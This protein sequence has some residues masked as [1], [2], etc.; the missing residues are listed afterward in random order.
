M[1]SDRLRSPSGT[2]GRRWATVAVVPA[3][4]LAAALPAAAAG[5]AAAVPSHVTP[6]SVGYVGHAFGTSVTVASGLLGSGP[7]ANVVTG[8][9]DT[10][11]A[12]RTNTTAGVTVPGVLSTGV[13][14]TS[15]TSNAS[16]A[17]KSEV[18]T[19]QVAGVSLLGGEIAATAVSDSSTSSVAG[20]T[21]STSGQSTFVGLTVDGTSEAGSP[22]ANTVIPLPGIGSVTLNEQNATPGSDSTQL[23][24]TSIDIRVLTAN[25]FGLPVGAR[26]IVG[27]ALSGLVTAPSPLV[28]GSAFGT[29]LTALDGA[30]V[31]GRTAFQPLQCQGT[32]GVTETNS[33]AGTTIAGV[34]TDGTVTST[35]EGN[36]VARDSTATTSN[37]VENVSVLPGTL[38]T[39]ITA[40]ALTA[41]ANASKVNGAKAFSDTG[42]QFVGLKV[43]GFPLID[44]DVPANT[45]LTIP[46]VGTLYLHRVIQTGHGIEVRMIEL[47]ITASGLPEPVGTDLIVGDASAKVQ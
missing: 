35:A 41:Q 45:A 38:S 14:D 2:R 8:C 24:V 33:T 17:T 44:D 32:D 6:P 15:L 7:T 25:S 11:G 46:A 43:A 47:Q 31:S 20:S 12:T 22:P 29:S 36:L 5:A 30:V 28:G 40:D 16:G 42:S 37:T 26:V 3:A 19:S 21:F 39:L 10:P 18:A 4:L 1:N 13:V 23:V 27:R 9:T 34:L